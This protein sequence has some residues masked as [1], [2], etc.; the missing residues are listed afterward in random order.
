MK[1]QES[2]L[3]PKTAAQTDDVVG[4]NV[5]RL[6]VPLLAWP[7]R[8][9][10]WIVRHYW[11]MELVESFEHADEEEE[12]SKY[13]IRC[14]HGGDTGNSG[15]FMPRDLETSYGTQFQWI[16]EAFPFILH[17]DQALRSEPTADVERKKESGI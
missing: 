2:D 7:D 1:H 11:G 3:K 17:N 12:E 14:H 10:F 9:G 16:G 13:A 5:T 4:V 15:P 6:V 8:S